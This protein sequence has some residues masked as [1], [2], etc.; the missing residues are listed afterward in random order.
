MLIRQFRLL[1]RSS[2]VTTGLVLLKLAID[3]PDDMVDEEDG[4]EDVDDRIILLLR[5]VD[6]FVAALDEAS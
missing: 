3:D 2:N 4:N 5:S 6:C 1:D